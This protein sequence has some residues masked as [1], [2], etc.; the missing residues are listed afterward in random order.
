MNC[1]ISGLEINAKADGNLVPH[2]LLPHEVTPIKRPLYTNGPPKI[3]Y[4]N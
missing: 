1:L 4:K 3:K 2:I